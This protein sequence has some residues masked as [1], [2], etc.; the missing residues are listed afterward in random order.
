MTRAGERRA[1][2][3]RDARPLPQ[4]CHWGFGP[5][6]AGDYAADYVR[7]VSVDWQQLTCRRPPA[8][9]AYPSPVPHDLM[10]ILFGAIHLL[11]GNLLGATSSRSPGQSIIIG[12]STAARSTQPAGLLLLAGRSINS[13]ISQ[14]QHRQSSTPAPIPN[15]SQQRPGL[16]LLRRGRKNSVRLTFP[17][18]ILHTAT[19]QFYSTIAC[20]IG[21]VRVTATAT[22]R[23]HFSCA[24]A[25]SLLWA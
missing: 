6:L 12:L 11:H 15:R 18:L 3:I 4:A 7:A 23:R 14:F 24:L 25:F 16:V 20:A 5:W 19:D 21:R 13:C 2:P 9:H 10:A 1:R 22:A 17:F 8:N